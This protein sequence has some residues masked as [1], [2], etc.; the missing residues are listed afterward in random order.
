MT[1]KVIEYCTISEPAI[2][3]VKCL[4]RL[5]EKLNKAIKEGWQPFGSI[6]AVSMTLI[7]IVVKY[8]E[9]E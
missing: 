2:D 4:E 5:D 3:G 9:V 8:E 6:T 7:Q 1:K